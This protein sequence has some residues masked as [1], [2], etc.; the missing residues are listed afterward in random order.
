MILLNAHFRRLLAV[1][2]MFEHW[3]RGLETGTHLGGEK[4]DEQRNRNKHYYIRGRQTDKSCTLSGSLLPLGRMCG[5]KLPPR[6]PVTK[7]RPRQ[8]CQ[9][10]ECHNDRAVSNTMFKNTK[11][12]LLVTPCSLFLLCTQCVCVCVCVCW[13]HL[14]DRRKQCHLWVY[15]TMLTSATGPVKGTAQPKKGIS[16]GDGESLQLHGEKRWSRRTSSTT[17]WGCK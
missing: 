2:V 13:S 4:W 12:T 9:T 11:Q 7:C 3:D 8:C 14:C 17:C 16:V 5:C 15:A 1:W 6:C 10:I